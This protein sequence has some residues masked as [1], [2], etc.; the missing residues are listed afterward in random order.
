MGLIGEEIGVLEAR[1]YGAENL[2][3]GGFSQGCA[4][5]M[6][7]L[8]RGGVKLGAFVGMSGWMPFRRQIAEVVEGSN[9]CAGRRLRALEYMNATAPIS[10]GAGIFTVQ[11]LEGFETPVFLGHGMLDAK[12]RTEWGEQMRELLGILEMNVRWKGYDGLEHWYM[13]P[14]EIDD[15]EDFL[16]ERGFCG[17]T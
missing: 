7:V 8:F 17:A 5:G 11:V 12:V 1:G 16:R 4:M 15:I 13:V 6:W 2:V 10:N 14:N 9:E 3:L